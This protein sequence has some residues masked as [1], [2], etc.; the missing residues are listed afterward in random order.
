MHTPEILWA[1][2]TRFFLHIPT[3]LTFALQFSSLSAHSTKGRPR[4]F[5]NLNLKGAKSC[6]RQ[7]EGRLRYLLGSPQSLQGA[8]EL[9]EHLYRWRGLGDSTCGAPQSRDGAFGPW[10]VSVT[11]KVGTRPGTQQG[12]Q[13]VPMHLRGSAE[14]P[15]NLLPCGVAVANFLDIC[16]KYIR[17]LMRPTELLRSVRDPQL[18][19][20]RVPWSE[21]GP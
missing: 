20:N 9:S 17:G 16:T 3:Q 5:V 8:T 6:A 15:E 10:S 1:C 11:S 21:L 12:M 18:R 7:P 13:R 2:K 14:P 4:S 19:P